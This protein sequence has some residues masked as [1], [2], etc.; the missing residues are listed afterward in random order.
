MVIWLVEML[1]YRGWKVG[2]VS[3]GYKGNSKN[4]P[5]ILDNTSV[6]SECGDEPIL[7]WKRT[8][9]L[10]AVSPKRVD[11]VFKLLSVQPSLDIIISDDGLQHYALFRDIE[12]V[13][14]NGFLRFGN[15]YCLPAGPMRERVNRLNQVHAVIVNGISKKD[16][17]NTEEILMQLHPSV[18]IN[19]LT[20]ECK[21]LQFL[22]KVVAIAG[23]GYPLQFFKTLRKS[24]IFP[25]REI[26]FSDHQ[27]YSEKM[28]MSVVN[29]E[30][31]LLMTEK[32]A[33]KCLS[34]AR[35]NWW[36]L[37]VDAKINKID[38]VVLLNEVEKKIRF[39]KKKNDSKF[40]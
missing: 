5:I 27:I 22:R 40:S 3:R 35:K 39:Y 7:I 34:F 18:I 10:V 32:D 2:V 31:T 17:I 19:I 12:W 36:Y 33:I 30:E 13:M 25:I 23:I 38:E 6:S 11:A 20:G 24:G 1:K 14:I 4:Y 16:I 15:G 8:G 26:S 29:Q 9:I 28:L 37:R 21:P